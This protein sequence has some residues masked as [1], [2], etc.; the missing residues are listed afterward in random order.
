VFKFS[1]KI[2]YIQ[3]S[4]V[5]VKDKIAIKIH[6]EILEHKRQFTGMHFWASGYYVST[7]DLNETEIREYVKNQEKLYKEKSNN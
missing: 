1:T 2:Q 4:W 5:Y 7:I 6:L 3:G